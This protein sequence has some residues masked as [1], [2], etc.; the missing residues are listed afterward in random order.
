MDKL[1]KAL[2]DLDPTLNESALH[3]VGATE[4]EE[5]LRELVRALVMLKGLRNSEAS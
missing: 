4:G 1:V 3:F 2:L 5:K